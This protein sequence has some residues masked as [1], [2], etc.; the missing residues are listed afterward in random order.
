MSG[1][2]FFPRFGPRKTA[3]YYPFRTGM[4]SILRRYSISK[5]NTVSSNRET[6]FSIYL[7]IFLITNLSTYIS[8]YLYKSFNLHI[9]RL[10]F[11][12]DAIFLSS[13][14]LIRDHLT[15]VRLWHLRF[16]LHVTVSAIKKTRGPIKTRG[17]SA[18]CHIHKINYYCKQYTAHPDPGGLGLFWSDPDPE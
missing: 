8:F 13:L 7:H 15:F 16:A 18:K 6:R 11:I 2:L 5:P 17:F 3:G 9:F 1:P 4:V 10:F 12:S 14:S